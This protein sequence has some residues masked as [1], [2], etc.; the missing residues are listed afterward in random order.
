MPSHICE[1]NCS[2]D[3]FPKWAC[4]KESEYKNVT[5]YLPKT[6]MRQMHL[7]VQVKT[8]VRDENLTIS[9]PTERISFASECLNICIYAASL[10]T[11]KMNL[12]G[13]QVWK[14]VSKKTAIM[15]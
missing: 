7:N 1:D 13:W 9:C 11:F 2:L 15:C 6:G 14:K 5:L 12:E 4:P 8:F 10:Y 3:T